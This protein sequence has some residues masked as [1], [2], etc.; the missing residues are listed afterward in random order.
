MM[1]PTTAPLETPTIVPASEA[2]WDDLVA[3]FGTADYPSRF[4]CQRLRVVGRIW[5][6]STI[7]LEFDRP[8]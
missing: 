6:D 5:R 7:R 3:V 4:R 8:A 1:A 2:S